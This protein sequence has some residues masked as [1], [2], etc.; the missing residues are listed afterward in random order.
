VK[1]LSAFSFQLSVL[2]RIALFVGLAL[3]DE[4]ALYARRAKQA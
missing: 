4:M 2:S 1:E 3:I